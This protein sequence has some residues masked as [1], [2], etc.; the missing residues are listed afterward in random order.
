M[1]DWRAMA[2]FDVV[3]CHCTLDILFVRVRVF[4]KVFFFAVRNN[5]MGAA[6]GL[7]GVIDGN[8]LLRGFCWI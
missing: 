8:D 4:L 2:G 3:C 7:R 1:D 6:G 5:W